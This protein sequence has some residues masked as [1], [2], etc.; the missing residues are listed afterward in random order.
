MDFVFSANVSA[1]PPATP[2]TANGYPQDGNPLASKVATVPGAYAW[3]MVFKELIGL[4]Q[5]GGE[6]PDAA[7]LTQVATAVQNIANAAAS[8]A[9]SAAIAA[10]A[11]DA[12]T[13]ANNAQSNA[14]AAAAT[15]ATSKANAAVTTAVADVDAQFTGTHQNLTVASGFQDLIGGQTHQWVQESATVGDGDVVI[16]YSKSFTGTAPIPQITIADVSMAGGSPNFLG[17]AVSAWSPTG[18][19]VSFG[20]N[21]GGSRAITV[22]VDAWGG[23]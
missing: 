9:Q 18:C 10:A 13:K 14:I 6:G 19:T 1:T 20:T 17:Y 5:E 22:R 2:G 7:T 8:T 23:S 12:T 11:S 15:D 16:A 21:G 3:Y 4:I